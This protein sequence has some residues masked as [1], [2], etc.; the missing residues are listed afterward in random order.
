M[1]TDTSKITGAADDLSDKL[2]K[3]GSAAK[4]LGVEIANAFKSLDDRVAALEAGGETQPPINPPIE[5][6]TSDKGVITN[7]NAANGSMIRIDNWEAEVE[8]ANRNYSLANPDKYTLRFEVHRGDE[9]GGFSPGADRSEI[10]RWTTMYN[11]GQTA[12]AE[13]SMRIE[14]GTTNTASFCVFTQL[15]HK[16]SDTINPIPFGIEFASRTDKFQVI[17]RGTGGRDAVRWVDNAACE[18]GRW[19]AWKVIFM[20]GN[21]GKLYVWRDGVQIVNYNGQLGYG[22]NNQVFWKWGVYRGNNISEVL[23]ATVKNIYVSS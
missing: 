4:T 21:N 16:P 12:T 3:G 11:E 14:P 17:G 22:S 5:P 2:T 18:R 6:P 20:A 8:N 19:Y 23:A 10:D 1:A 9:W 15:H 7:F 13:F